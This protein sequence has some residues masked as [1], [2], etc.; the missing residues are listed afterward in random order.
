MSKKPNKLKIVLAGGG[1]GGHIYPAIAVGQLLKADEDIEKI[2]YIGNPKNI[3]K[4]IVEKER[5]EFLPVK[6]SGMPRKKDLSIIKWFVELAFAVN[7]CVSYFKKI[8]PD[9]I[10][11][12]GGYVS[13]PALLAGWFLEIP[14]IIHD[15]DTHPGIVSKKM[16]PK[17]KMVSVAFE[18]AKKYLNSKNILVNGN[19]IRTSFSIINKEECLNKLNLDKNK[20]TLLVMGGSQGAISLNRATQGCLNR[21]I[22]EQNIQIIHQTGMK[23]YEEYM[24]NLPSEYIDNPNYLVKPYFEDMSV[25]LSCSDLVVARAGSLSISELNLMGLPSILVPYPHSAADHQKYNAK[26]MEEVG[27]SVYLD[28][29]ECD[30][31]N[32]LEIILTLLNDKEKL[33]EMKNKNLELAKPNSGEN[34]VKALKEIAGK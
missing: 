14:F 16:A 5:F 23:N 9:V 25:P 21:L 30:S 1:T 18:Q 13:G 7:T 3:E 33:A 8:K 24:E 17:A 12:T 19:P 26:A 2:Y 10:F 31:E 32:L 4:N 27:A 15:C 20:F 28:D 22:N 11:G 29:K 6:I 34:I